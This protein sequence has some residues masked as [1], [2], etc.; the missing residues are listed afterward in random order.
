MPK[1]ALIGSYR[2]KQHLRIPVFIIA[3]PKKIASAVLVFYP[4]S[5]HVIRLIL[6][7]RV[8][9]IAIIVEIEVAIYLY[10]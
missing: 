5:I 9:T 3:S 6:H 10:G 2:Y 7:D 1:W 4:T 8:K